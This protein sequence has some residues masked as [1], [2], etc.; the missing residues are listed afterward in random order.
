MPSRG[1]HPDTMLSIS[2]SCVMSRNQYAADPAPVIDELYATAGDRIDLLEREIGQW[3][4]YYED[5]YTRALTAALR[6]L[7]FDMEEWIALGLKRRST[8]D[9]RTPIPR[10]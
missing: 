6:A 8:P 2:I 1:L 3:I 4:G 9:H 10:H 5:D 7:P